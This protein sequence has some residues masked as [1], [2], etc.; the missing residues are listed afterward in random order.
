MQALAKLTTTVDRQRRI[1]SD[2]PLIVPI[3]EL[4]TDMQA[5]ALYAQLTE[6]L[7]KYTRTLSSDRRHLV[8]QFDLIHVARK[9]VG[10]GSVGTR[11]WILL[12]E[13]GDG[14][15]PLFLQAK[16]AQASVLAGYCGRSSYANEGQRVVAGQHLMQAVSDIFLGWQR[17]T[18]DDSVERD[19]YVRQLRDW[20]LSIPIEQL[21]P[22]GMAIYAG[23][24]DGPWP[25]HTPGPAIGSH[26]PRTWGSPTR[27]TWPSPTSPKPTPTRTR[28]TTP[29]SPPPSPT[30][31]PKRSPASDRA[32]SWSSTEDTGLCQRLSLCVASGVQRGRRNH[33]HLPRRVVVGRRHH[34]HHSGL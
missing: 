17:A 13:A 20:K 24:C 22:T 1:I 14:Q 3:E 12:L 23:L 34:H 5:D 2:P 11:A 30:A 15:E 6:L 16:E 33:H 29:H 26:L 28:T 31:V 7:A 25:A 32:A 8:Q 9:V 21:R 27:S 19:F 4:F 18:G 10:V